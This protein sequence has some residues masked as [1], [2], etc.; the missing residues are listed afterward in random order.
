MDQN[1]DGFID[2]NDL[3]DTFAALGRQN[4]KQE[5]IDMMLKDA[6][7]PINFTV[8]LTMFGE[9]LKGAD[10]EETILNAFKV[11]DP[12]GK[13]ILKKEYIAQVL[14]TQAER[15]S[16]VEIEQMFTAFPP[17]VAGNLDYK[18]LVYIITH[19]EDNDQE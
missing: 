16:A 17:D 7:G 13:G 2:K 3:R 15:F 8:F 4:V 12:E 9:K 18:N 5:E 1:S 19:G 14:T 11:F 6:P 10:P